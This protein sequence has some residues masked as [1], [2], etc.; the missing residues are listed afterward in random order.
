MKR[1]ILFFLAVVCSL[2]SIF[3]R[4]TRAQSL[5]LS[6]SPPLLEVMIKPGKSITQVFKIS[7]EGDTTIVILKIAQM[8]QNGINEDPS[9]QK[10]NWIT[11]ANTD[12]ALEQPFLLPAK[13]QKQLILKI[14]PPAGTVE[15][16]YYR[17][18]TVNTKPNPGQE[19]SQSLVTQTLGA[20]L[21]ILVSATGM[22]NK[23]GT[24]SRFQTPQILDSFDPLTVDIDI[25]NTGNTY[26]R[27]VGKI[28]LTGPIGKGTYEIAPRVILTDQTRMI[29][30]DNELYQQDG[31]HTLSLPGFYIG[32]Y[33]IEADISLDTPATKLT[34]K[35]VFYALPWKAGLILAGIVLIVFNFSGKKKKKAGK[36]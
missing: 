17:A 31:S 8:T 24:V 19:S 32:K 11:L 25:K 1:K 2:L 20:P 14:N 4:I 29:T 16:N 21:L 12:I 27:T 7:N 3:P 36:A 30:T 13:T 6:I 18:I 34:V 26:F 28:S 9:F 33:E 22:I 23:S 10:E 5:S 35:K 15:Q